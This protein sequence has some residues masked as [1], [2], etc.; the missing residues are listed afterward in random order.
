MLRG[1]LTQ[2]TK[3]DR[4]QMLGN[5]FAHADVCKPGHARSC[6]DS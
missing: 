1:T 6:A 5:S 2:T 3:A 4:I